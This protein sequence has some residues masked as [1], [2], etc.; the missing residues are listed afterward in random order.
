MIIS[1]FMEETPLRCSQARDAHQSQHTGEQ[2]ER[3]RQP[4]VDGHQAQP[5]RLKTG[6]VIAGSWSLAANS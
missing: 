1:L 2:S 5:E 4:Q 6:N 3:E